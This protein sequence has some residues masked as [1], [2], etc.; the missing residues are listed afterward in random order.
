MLALITVLA[1]CG[2]SEG[3]A[4]ASCKTVRPC[5]G[6]VV[7]TWTFR[8]SCQ[9]V[10]DFTQGVACPGA[11]LD[12][13]KKMTSGAIVFNADMTYAASATQSGRMD[14]NIP[15]SCT[16]DATCQDFE[17]SINPMPPEAR[18]V[19]IT[20]NEVCECE[21]TWLQPTSSTASGTY[22]T[23]GNILDMMSGTG[24][25]SFSGGYCVRGNELHLLS[26]DMTTG[27]VTGDLVATK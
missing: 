1:G 17:G 14:F 6:S 22:T 11:T 4:A 23:D 19:C 26:T 20:S 21:L 12:E 16:Q 3:G 5:G 13:S 25:P 9:S 24:G 15:L 27:V 2:S 8:A 18:A 7:G 10:T